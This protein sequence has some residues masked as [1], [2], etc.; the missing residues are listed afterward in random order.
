[1]ICQPIRRNPQGKGL[2]L[3]RL[4][5]ELDPENHRASLVYAWASGIQRTAL[6]RA[7]TFAPQLVPKGVRRLPGFDAKV[8]SLYARGLTVR[9]I[10]GHLEELYQRGPA[11]ATGSVPASQANPSVRSGGNPQAHNRSEQKTQRP[12]SPRSISPTSLEA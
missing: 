7:G 8:L 9:E 2:D 10:Q 12:G 3:G 11:G 4:L 1:L 6:A 5:L